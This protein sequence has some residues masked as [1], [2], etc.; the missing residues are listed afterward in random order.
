MKKMRN[1]S[2]EKNIVC[3]N[4]YSQNVFLFSKQKETKKNMH[5]LFS[6]KSNLFFLTWE[7][8]EGIK[9]SIDI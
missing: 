6:D 7:E 3:L 1:L 5:R 2:L 9:C 8:K 4:Q